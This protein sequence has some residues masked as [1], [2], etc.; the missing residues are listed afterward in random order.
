MGHVEYDRLLG[1]YDVFGFFGLHL[2]STFVYET[3]IMLTVFGGFSSIVEA[4]AHP[5][6]SAELDAATL[7]EAS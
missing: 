4:I 7:E 1:L 5:Q 6:E 3:S 2:T